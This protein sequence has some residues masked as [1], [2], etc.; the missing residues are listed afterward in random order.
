MAW[1]VAEF[2]W[3]E[4]GPAAIDGV[5]ERARLTPPSTPPSS[6]SGGNGASSSGSSG[7]SSGGSSNGNGNQKSKR[8]GSPNGNVAVV[9]TQQNKD[10]A[11]FN[12]TYITLGAR[13]KAGNRI[14]DP[15]ACE[16][17]GRL[18]YGPWPTDMVD[19]LVTASLPHVGDVANMLVTY[20]WT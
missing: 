11:I 8:N 10:G 1:C 19:I 5:L 16:E 3:M 17:C 13:D 18:N 12:A 7:G 9:L 14:G 4:M 2:D 20:Y 6:S 15:A